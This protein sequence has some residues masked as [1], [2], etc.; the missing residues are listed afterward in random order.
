MNLPSELPASPP[1]LKQPARLEYRML[2]EEELELAEPGIGE[3]RRTERRRHA[4]A[5]VVGT[6][7]GEET[8]QQALKA[9]SAEGYQRG[10]RE[11]SAKARSEAEA[12]MIGAAAR[13]QERVT[14]TIEE[15]AESK[16]MYFAEIE[17]QVVRLAL[18]IAA[19]VLHRETQMDALVMAGAVRVAL[20]K[21]AD[22]SG[23]T[24]RTAV[25]DV[26]AWQRMFVAVDD[27]PRVMGDVTL[28]RGEC[29]L[30]T[31]MG[32]VELG[33]QTQLEEIENGFFDLLRANPSAFDRAAA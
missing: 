28:A 17:G 25:A 1:V 21:L 7:L 11:G 9:A 16:R 12:E 32:T 30:E 15:F 5:P 26:A 24:L 18:A 2:V 20:D 8:L 14:Q 3:R 33:V 23:V 29:I 13:E 10:E 31:A 4:R 27:A 6:G 22:R 19:R